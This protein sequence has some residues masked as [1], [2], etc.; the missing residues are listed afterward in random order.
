[1]ATVSDEYA[2]A[3]N[4]A[5][6]F[7]EV[8]GKDFPDTWNFDEQPEL[9]GTYVSSITKEIKGKDRTIHTFNVNGEDV[10]AWGTAIL[11]SRL[12]GT[13]GSRVKVVKTGEKLAT[14]SGHR[15]WE[16]KVYVSRSALNRG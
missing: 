7:V 13:E 15:A 2:E 4:E 3:V 12:E 1:M 10:N 9:V 8:K 11:D 16:Y 5:D 6:E 14:K